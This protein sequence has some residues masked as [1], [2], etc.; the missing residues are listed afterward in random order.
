MNLIKTAMLIAVMTILF[1]V[2]GYAIGGETGMFLAFIAAAA[3]NLFS[4]WNSGKMVLKMHNAMAVDEQTSPILV[5]MVADLAANAELPMPKVYVLETE[6][7]NAFA[8][9]RS[10]AHAAIAVSTGL[11]DALEEDEVA[12]V[13]AH[14]LG[15]I[16]SRDT[17]TMTLTATLAGAIGMIANYSMFFGR[18]NFIASMATM[19]LAPMAAGVVQMAISRTRE[20]EADR[21]GAE[22]SGLPLSLASALKK[23]EAI[24]RQTN[25]GHAEHNPGTAHLFIINPLN[26]KGVDGLFSTHPKTVNRVAEL[27]KLAAEW[28][29]SPHQKITPAPKAKTKKERE[30]WGREAGQWHTHDGEPDPTGPWGDKSKNK[31]PWA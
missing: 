12:A 21:D 17:L 29:L 25:N 6:Q 7:P 28:Q 15:H 23:I 3:M 9:G 30:I 20:Y 31:G 4:W 1:M 16:K 13:I 10:P 24:A 19:I 5:K 27:E 14:E 8:T 26:G 22:I 18:R 11:L 2:V